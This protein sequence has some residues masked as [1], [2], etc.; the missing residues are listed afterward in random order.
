MRIDFHF[1]TIYALARAVGFSPDNARIIAYSSQYT[2]DEVA[3]NT[4]IFENGGEFKP[5]ITAHK[6]FDPANLLARDCK[7]IWI[8][9]HFLPGTSGT[10]DE[11]ILTRPDCRVSQRIIEQFLSYDLLPY[12]R[13]LLGIILHSYADTWS[14][15]NFMGITD[16]LNRV[17][18]LKVDGVAISLYGL[19]PALGHAQTGSTP[20]IPSLEWEYRDYQGELRHII[21]HDR[22]LAAAHHCYL[23]LSRFLDKFADDFRDFKAISWEQIQ[24]KIMT[25]FQHASDE[26]ECITAWGTAIGNSELGFNS[27]GKDI[28]LIYDEGEW[29]NLAIKSES[30]MDPES[31]QFVDYYYKNDNYDVSDLK[32]F[33]EAAAFYRDTLFVENAREFGLG[34]YLNL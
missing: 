2:D 22:A 5:N 19:A 27:Q 9:F 33:N 32:Y 11:Q 13:H 15:Q 6:I 30:R 18:G 34:D 16:D 8:P 3:E 10:G 4:I 25:L 31:G 1:Y 23:V 29:F 20:D 24:D 26:K 21:N 7:R 17:Q 12:S 14:H 28:N